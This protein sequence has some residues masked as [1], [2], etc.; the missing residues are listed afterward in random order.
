MAAERI[1]C[2]IVGYGPVFNWGHMHGRW[3]QAVPAMELVA[4]CD[5]D[6]RCVAQAEIDFPGIATY[7]DLSVMLQA[8]DLDL[9]T[10]ITPHNTHAELAIQ[11][12]KAGKHVV[13]EKPMCVTIAEANRMM[14]AAQQAGKSLAVYHNRRHDG[15]VRLI[16]QLVQ[17]GALGEIFHIEVCTMGY[18]PGCYQGPDAPWR[19]SKVVSGGGLYDWGAHAVDWVLTLVESPML[20]ITGFFHRLS[21]TEES[22][23][24]HAR[25]LIRF[26]N[27]CAAEICHSQAAL[28][29]K[30]Y[31]WYILGT[32]GAIMDTGS[33][34]ISGYCQELNG[35]CGG[36]LI[37]RNSTDEL[38]LP[39]M[40]SDWATY[41]QE[42]ADHLLYGTPVPVSAEQ[43]RRVISVLQTAEQAATAGHSLPA[44][45]P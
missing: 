32:E 26:A 30:P 6:S 43:G 41:Y 45:Y 28:I 5:C 22:N 36:N 40:E 21:A 29:S 19:A 2:A 11:C 27:G 20:D 3:L 1:R 39:Y 35:P 9:V 8:V 7:T 44:P 16:Y 4:V 37:L 17:S 42:L 24:D 13:V 12:L 14:R 31:L 18:A 23:E 10:I 25:A 34:A 33:G 38:S 15:N